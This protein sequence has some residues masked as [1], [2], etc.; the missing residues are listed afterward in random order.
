MESAKKKV[1]EMIAVNALIASVFVVLG[2]VILFKGNTPVTAQNTTRQ[3]VAFDRGQTEWDGHINL[4]AGD[5]RYYITCVTPEMTEVLAD[6]GT[7]A[8]YEVYTR[9]VNDTDGPDYERVF[10]LNGPDGTAYLTFEQASARERSTAVVIF[11]I[12]IGMVVF[13]GISVAV[14][15]RSMDEWKALRRARERKRNGA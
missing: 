13:Y 5:A 2:L 3:V 6:C 1:A 11:W 4:Y 8:R 12:C 9:H 10:A 15:V 14:K 7:G